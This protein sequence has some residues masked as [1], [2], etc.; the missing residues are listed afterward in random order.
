MTTVQSINLPTR[1]ITTDPATGNVVATAG[2]TVGPAFGNRLIVMDPG[3]ATIVDSVFVGSEPTRVAVSADGSLAYVGLD[4]AGAVRIVDLPSLTPGT[5]FT[6]PERFGPTRAEDIDVS[7]SDPT[8]VLVSAASSGVSPRHAG[9]FAYTN[10]VELPDNTPNHTG[11][12]R[13]AFASDGLL[14]GYNNETTGFGFYKHE[15]DANGVRRIES[16]GRLISGFGVDF[17]TGGTTGLSTTGIVLDLPSMTRK[18]TLA[19]SGP[20]AINPA[21]NR[22]FVL[23]N[24]EIHVYDLDT[25]IQ[26]G[27]IDI[28]GYANGSDLIHTGGDGLA[29]RTGSQ[30]VFVRDELVPEPTSLAALSGGMLLLGRRRRKA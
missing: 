4:G 30:V 11:S 5:Q 12:N 16:V 23:R 14:Y 19:T 6:L 8:T 28:P 7:P 17:T 26:I 29:F 9:V 10:G 13:I 25:F 21:N 1:G 20:S 24:Q 15:V 3:S 22:A 18:G 2:S 27:T